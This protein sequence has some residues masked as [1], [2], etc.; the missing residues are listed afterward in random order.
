MHCNIARCQCF[1]VMQ[2]VHTC[3]RLSRISRGIWILHDSCTSRLE[4][5]GLNNAVMNNWIILTSY[6]PLELKPL[7]SRPSIE[8]ASF[9]FHFI[10]SKCLYICYQWKHCGLLEITHSATGALFADCYVV[11][12]GSRWS[13]FRWHPVKPLTSAENP[14][15]TL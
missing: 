15:C 6:Q 3:I 7:T 1:P 13:H 2:V 8:C 9:F 12:N 5:Y 14:W 10:L 4:R 11:V